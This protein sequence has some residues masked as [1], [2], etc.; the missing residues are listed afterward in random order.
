MMKRNRHPQRKNEMLHK[1]MRE[2]AVTMRIPLFLNTV[3]AILTGTLGIVTANIIENFANA[4]FELNLLLGIKNAIALAVCLTAVV[5]IAPAL[6]MVSDF[7]M[8]KD[9]LRHDNIVFGH[10]LDKDPEKE[11]TFNSGEV[12]Y[13]LEDAPNDL[14][15]YWINLMSKLLSFPFCFGYLLYCSGKISWLLTGVM[16]LLAA[17]KLLLPL[18]FKEP[19]AEFNRQEKQYL[20]MRRDYESDAVTNLHI[21]KMWG[22]K[23]LF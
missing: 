11:R 15:I 19:L 12:Q 3:T 9:A 21:I 17:I 16:V 10:Y 4:A 8:L 20:A 18:F 22:I 6:R 1:V 7:I 5:F 2:C 14:R 23:N 13:K